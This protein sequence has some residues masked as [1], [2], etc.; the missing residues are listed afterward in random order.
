MLDTE[1]KLEVDRSSVGQR[2]SQCDRAGTQTAVKAASIGLR[3]SYLQCR[4]LD[5]NGAGCR[6]RRTRS[7]TRTA[8]IDAG[9]H[10]QAGRAKP[11]PESGDRLIGQFA[12]ALAG[13]LAG[14]KPA[15]PNGI[16]SAVGHVGSS[17]VPTEPV[18]LLSAVRPAVTRRLAMAAIPLAVVLLLLATASRRT[19]QRR[20]RRSQQ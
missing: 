14:D 12:D 7:S 17:D 16:G 9:N 3:L 4:T 8:V 5:I 10:D 2:C 1:Q 19:S 11:F 6:R 20:S 15:A 18:D 13:Q